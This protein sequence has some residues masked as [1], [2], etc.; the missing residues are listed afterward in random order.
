MKAIAILAL[1]LTMAQEVPQDIPKKDLPKL[2]ECSVC[3]AKGNPMG[4]EKPA[5]GVTYKGQ[6]YYFCNS[7]EVAEFKKD[8][9]AF[10]PPVIPREMPNFSLADMDG[11]TWDSAAMKGKLV[12][13]DYWATWCVPCKE[14][15]PVLD[16]LREK[17]K[18]KGFELLSV[19][20]D[21]KKGD[22]DK[23]LKGHKFPNPVLHD[24]AGT[25]SEWGIRFIP[26]S[27]LIRD[28]K[29]VAQWTGKTSEKVLAEAIEANLPSGS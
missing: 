24:T 5:A 6:P 7:K 4:M 8:P 28:G 11:K 27:F 16:K 20:V 26:A 23:Y 10:V 22:L 21:Q 15:F 2:A 17:Y 18:D 3:K 12:M 14:M 1:F 25:S 29:I 19:S 9:E 13:V